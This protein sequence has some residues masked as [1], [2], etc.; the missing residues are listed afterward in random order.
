MNDSYFDKLVLKKPTLS[1]IETYLC[2]LLLHG[3]LEVTCPPDFK[4]LVKPI[5][6]LHRD[7]CFTHFDMNEER[8]IFTFQK[9]KS[10]TEKVLVNDEEMYLN[11]FD[12]KVSL[13][14]NSFEG[15]KIKDLFHIY[16]GFVCSKD[17]LFK[18]EKGNYY[19]ITAPDK[20]ERYIF[21]PEYPC[22]IPYFNEHLEKHKADLMMIKF[23]NWNSWYDIKD[24]YTFEKTFNRKFILYDTKTKK[25][26]IKKSVHFSDRFIGLVPKSEKINLEE[27]CQKIEES[28]ENNIKNICL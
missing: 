19:V 21:T 12:D 18:H 4:K 2:K 9:N 23:E 11:I 7:G 25:T 17:K 22:C 13:T 5:L 24:M 8:I 14:K 16:K 20:I 15:F 26:Q 3:T 10:Q 28:H 6:K 27:I 1:K